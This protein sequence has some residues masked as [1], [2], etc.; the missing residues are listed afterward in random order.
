MPG[1]APA[2]GA[3]PLLG[4]WSGAVD[5]GPELTQSPKGHVGTRMQVGGRPVMSC[6][7]LEQAFR[8]WRGCPAAQAG[9]GHPVTL[10]SCSQKWSRLDKKVCG[11]FSQD[12]TSLSGLIIWVVILP[13]L[14]I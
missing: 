9:W 4:S 8:S 1:T 10:Q 13:K 6:A 14:K 5:E 3:R 12:G 11:C 2:G 7:D